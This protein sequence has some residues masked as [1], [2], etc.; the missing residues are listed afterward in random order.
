MQCALR[1]ARYAP[2]FLFQNAAGTQA[3]P[4]DHS[5]TVLGHLG[6]AE[7]HDA[8]RRSI[9]AS[10]T[11]AIRFTRTKRPHKTVEKGRLPQRR[12]R[13]AS[14]ASCSGGGA[15][16]GDPRRDGGAQRGPAEKT[17][18]WQAGRDNDSDRRRIGKECRAIGRLHPPSAAG[19]A[20]E[21]CWINK[22]G[23]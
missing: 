11:R 20:R 4:S 14:V 9:P 23:R 3:P 2:S 19:R 12:P 17:H 22:R 5:R 16:S 21:I 7:A 18:I 1:H 15:G 6:S 10:D 13:S 8:P